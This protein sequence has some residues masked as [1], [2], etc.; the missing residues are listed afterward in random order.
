MTPRPILWLA[1][2][3]LLTACE[4]K[5]APEAAAP[6]ADAPTTPVAEASDP[7]AE[8]DVPPDLPTTADFEV[9]AATT[10][11][12]DSYRAD[13]AALQAEIESDAN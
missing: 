10:I 11:T 13:L 5:Q 12:S 7:A 8:A 9:E 4:T 6:S 1:A 3:L 2:A